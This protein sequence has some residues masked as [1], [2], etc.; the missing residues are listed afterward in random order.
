MPSGVVADA[1]TKARRRRRR[2]HEGQQR[3]PAFGKAAV[4]EQQVGHDAFGELVQHH[5]HGGEKAGE[6]AHRERDRVDEAVDERV[7]ADAQHRQHAQGQIPAPRI[8]LAH[9]GREEAVEQVHAEEASK[10]EGRAVGVERERL[11]D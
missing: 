5:A 10:Q 3:R 8:P 2:R 9:E 6:R 11:R 1:A 7:Q 4:R